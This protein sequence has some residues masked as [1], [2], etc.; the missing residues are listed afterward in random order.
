MHERYG[1]AQRTPRR[2]EVVDDQ[3]PIAFLDPVPLD[4]ES[5]PLAVFGIVR[6]RRDGIWHLPTLAHHDERHLQ[7]K[8]D[9]RAEDEASCVESRDGI[10]GM[11]ALPGIPR[12]ENVNDLLEYVGLG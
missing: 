6:A 5:A 7:R 12:D 8:G 9:G 3:Y 10:D 1:R 4:G 11:I 2:H